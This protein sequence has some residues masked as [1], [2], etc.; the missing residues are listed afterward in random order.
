MASCVDET[1]QVHDSC[2]PMY[3]V[4]EWNG[5]E[6]TAVDDREPVIDA[7]YIPSNIPLNVD[8]MLYMSC[9]SAG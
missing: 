3:D 2:R 4:D 5:G 8:G 7:Q 9:L 1:R 6:A